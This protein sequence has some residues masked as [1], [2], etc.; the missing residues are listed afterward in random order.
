MKASFARTLLLAA[1]LL[2][3]W[4]QTA[5]CVDSEKKST[6]PESESTSLDPG[7][8]RE[9]DRNGIRFVYYQPQVDEWKNL[10]ELRARVAFTLTPKGGKPA[11]GIEELKGD[12]VADLERR[13]V[14]INNIEIVAVRFPSLPDDETG[15]SS[16]QGFETEVCSEHKLGSLLRT[17]RL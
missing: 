12:T 13:T 16:H 3:F 5:L 10:R 2:P 7:W 11:V 15:F 17:V 8:P 1:L 6:N 9:L 4:P 14:Q